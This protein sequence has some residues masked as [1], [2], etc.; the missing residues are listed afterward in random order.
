VADTSEQGVVAETE[1]VVIRPWR[2][3]EADRFYDMHRRVEVAEWISGRPMA[4]RSKAIALIEEYR[5]RLAGD[6]RFGAWAVIE[7]SAGTPAGTVLLKPLPDGEGE[8]EIGW[9]LDPDS[10]GRGLATEAADALLAHG[11]AVGLEEVW[12]VTHPHNRP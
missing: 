8:I 12:A 6:P 5:A 10:W 4:D 2:S 7:R 3:D 9:H 1:R 11:F